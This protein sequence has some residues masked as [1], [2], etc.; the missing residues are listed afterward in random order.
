LVVFRELASKSELGFLDLYLGLNL[1]SS[2]SDITSGDS[3][4][5]NS[6]LEII[7]G[8]FTFFLFGLDSSKNASDEKFNSDCLFI[9]I[10]L[11]NF[12][13]S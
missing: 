3:K 2:S 1:R 8:D 5:L 6:L 13:V 9:F 12:V 11:L 4:N 10:H 7:G